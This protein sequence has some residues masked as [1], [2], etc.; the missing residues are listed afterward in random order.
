VPY[1]GGGAVLADVA[2][3]HIASTMTTPPAAFPLAKAGRLKLLAQAAAKRSPLLPDVPTFAESGVSDVLVSNWYGVLGVGG[4]P[5]PV[6]KRLHSELLRAIAAPD[7][8]ERLTTSG[9]EPAPLT[10][11][12]FSSMIVGEVERWKRV[13]RESGIKPE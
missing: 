2:A 10:P 3:G 12:Q 1:K 9:L 5:Q 4:T 6:V 7:M 11:D 13:A 8:R